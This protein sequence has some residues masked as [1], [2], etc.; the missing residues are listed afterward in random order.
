VGRRA[1]VGDGATRR[2]RGRSSCRGAAEDLVRLIK[3]GN[4]GALLRSGLIRYVVADPE[5]GSRVDVFGLLGSLARRLGGSAGLG[6]GCGACEDPNV[7]SDGSV[8]EWERPMTERDA[9]E[10]CNALALSG[11]VQM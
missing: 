9:R 6:T 3:G 1:G 11:Q 5:L 8:P 4:V 2:R 10:R 7:P